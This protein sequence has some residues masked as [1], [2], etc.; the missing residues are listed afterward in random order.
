MMQ[1]KT[2]RVI[3]ALA[4]QPEIFPFVSA[5]PSQF[6]LDFTE[7]VERSEHYIF[8][9]NGSSDDDLSATIAMMFE[10]SGPDMYEMHTMSRS[11][12]RGGDAFKFAKA[13]IEEM[14]FNRG[15]VEIWGQTPAANERARAFNQKLGA[16][17]R[18]FGEHYLF[19]PVEFFRTAR[20]EY[21]DGLN[22]T[23]NIEVTG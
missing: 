13:C 5:D 11:C 1:A 23:M 9:H 17:P 10:W 21:E 2:A 6:P 7:C 16:I 20:A 14:F 22:R 19:G 15:A 12:A 4:N 18:G 3:N 8:F